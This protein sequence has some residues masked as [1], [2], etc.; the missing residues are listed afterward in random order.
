M[1]L[2]IPLLLLAASFSVSATT[3][4]RA[5][6]FETKVCLATHIFVGAAS[7]FAVVPHPA[8]DTRGDGRF[9][10]MCEEVQVSVAVTEV[11]RPSNWQPAAPLTF[12]FGGGLFSV[13]SL[14]SDLL[15]KPRYFFVK[16][17]PDGAVFRTSY[18]WHLG[19]EA[20][21]E[22][23]KLVNEALGKCVAPNSSFKPKPLRGS[24]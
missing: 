22:T 14:R 23:E 17:S 6:P 13:S 12:R 18:D 3:P 8:C 15:G 1:N 7:D 11:L 9:L 4:P 20:N 5:V 19:A 10:T 21:P 16:Q 2:R 24:A